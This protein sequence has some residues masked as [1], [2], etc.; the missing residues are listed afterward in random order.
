MR[1]STSM[2]FDRG[3]SSMQDRTAEVLKLQQQ[4]AANRRILTPSDDPVAAAQ[5]LEITQAKNV[6]E[7]YIQNQ[8]EAS[9]T[10]A[11]GESQLND[12]GT[13]LQSTY[14]KIVQL[15]DGALA[16]QDRASIAT[17]LRENFKQLMSIGNQTDGLGKYIFGG[18]RGDTQPFVGDIDNGV[19]YQGD[20]GHRELQVSASRSLQVSE[21]GLDV[22]MRVPN[23]SVPFRADAAS[24]NTGSATISTPTVTD[25]SLWNVAGN[26]QIYD[27]TFTDAGGGDFSYDITD[28]QGNSIGTGTYTPTLDTDGNPVPVQI[29]LPG[30]GA[31][32]TI[33]GTPADGDVVNIRPAGTTD[34]FSVISNV[35]DLAEQPYQSADAATRARYDEQLGYALTNIQSSLDNML[36]YRAGFGARMQEAET[37][38]SAGSERSLEYTNTLSRLQDVDMTQAI[39]DLTKTQTTLQA[40]QLSFSKVTQLSLF[41]Y[42]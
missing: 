40:A 26:A 11:L 39:S 31:E 13:L 5:A 14:E 25:A 7:L 24:T 27:V 4:L 17:Q 21:S 22:F 37:L 42:L 20:A 18:Y 36:K 35:V 15:G 12:A 3:V 32:F 19:T 9:D 38:Q 30:L 28:Y 8:A 6:N 23:T 16:D 2:L 10:M 34:V 33:S 1:V 29:A 41:N